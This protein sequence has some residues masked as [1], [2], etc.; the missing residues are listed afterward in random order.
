MLDEKQNHRRKLDQ[1]QRARIVHLRAQGLSQTAIAAR[2]GVSRAAIQNVL[3][4]PVLNP[5]HARRA[6]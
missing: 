6:A 5:A 3:K 2:M 1:A 4:R